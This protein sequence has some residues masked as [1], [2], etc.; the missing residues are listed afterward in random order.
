M[1]MTV[2]SI[3]Y[4]EPGDEELF[5]RLASLFY[6]SNAA[7]QDVS[8]EDL[9]STFL[10]C[11]NDSPYIRGVFM[12]RDGEV[13]GYALLSFTYS[14]EYGGKIMAIDEIFIEEEFRNRGILDYFSAKIISDYK[15]EVNC[16][17]VA[18]RPGNKAVIRICEKLGF[19]QDEY[20][21]M[22]MDL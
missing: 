8:R 11:V 12:C 20:V 2:K 16:I 3:R 9:R 15:N 22:H 1:N 13:C 17:E 14:N 4:F 6:K 18:I 10:C 19:T 5:F 7:V 21:L